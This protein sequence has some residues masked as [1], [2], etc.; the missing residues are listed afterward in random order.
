[1]N[2]EGFIRFLDGCIRIIQGVVRKNKP[3]QCQ[4]RPMGGGGKGVITPP[5]PNGFGSAV[6]TAKFFY[7]QFL[8]PPPKKK[9]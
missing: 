2:W 8:P 3:C 9:N 1:M 7:F 5:R 6:G 4:G